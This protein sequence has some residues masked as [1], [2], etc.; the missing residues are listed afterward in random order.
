MGKLLR[1]QFE[2][3][4]KQLKDKEDKLHDEEAKAKINE[5]EKTISYWLDEIDKELANGIDK[6]DQELLEKAAPELKEAAKKIDSILVKNLEV[7]VP[8]LKDAGTQQ[9]RAKLLDAKL[10]AK[11]EKIL[12][13][14]QEIDPKEEG[15]GRGRKEE[16][17]ERRRKEEGIFPGPIRSR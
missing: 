10:P 8:G 2:K 5:V 11:K 15:A 6:D 1:T 17:T 14:L 13:K 12:K 4:M 16:G 3:A 9:A 7:E